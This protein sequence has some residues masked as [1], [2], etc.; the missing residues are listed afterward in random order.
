MSIGCSLLL[1]PCSSSKDSYAPYQSL[2]HR[3]VLEFL[4]PAASERLSHARRK[5]FEPGRLIPLAG[6]NV[7]G[8][9]LASGP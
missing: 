6:D 5:V 4:S 2:P 1:F 7:C 3:S 8:S 9:V